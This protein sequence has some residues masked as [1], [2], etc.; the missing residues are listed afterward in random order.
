ME[1][2]ELLSDYDFPGDDLPVI[3]GSALKGLEGDAVWEQKILELGNALTLT[4]QS[5]YVRL[6]SH[7]SCQS[8]TYSQLLVA[9]Q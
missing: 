1:V 5:Q 4:F 7:S 6:I 8:K 3:R 9:V 2:R